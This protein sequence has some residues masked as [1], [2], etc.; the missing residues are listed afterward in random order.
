MTKKIEAI[1]LDTGN[2]LRI[3]VPDAA[4]Q[5]AA[6]QQIVKLVGTQE[7]PDAFCE[8][9]TKRYAAYKETAY[10]TLL[11][12]SEKEL[13]TRWML[14]EYPAEKIMPLASRLTR[15]WLD[16]SGHRVPHSD[17]RPTIIELSNRG[18]L[19]GIIANS[20][21]ETEIPEW[22]AADGLAQYFK[23]VMLSSKFGRR[24]PD[25][26]I[27]LEAARAIGVKPENCAYVGD[28]P[29]RDIQGAR[30]AGYGMVLILLEQATLEKEPSRGKYKPDG[31]LSNCSE[32]LNI[33]F[34]R[35][36]V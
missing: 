5:A 7:Q 31:I 10:R 12:S 6:K 32:M 36:D 22:L 17:V 23:T 24:K 21:S 29:S 26:Y 18:Y 9:L 13:W 3:V 34:P 8:L 16:Q 11:Q 2:T 20:V 28:N 14:P 30:Q 15:L 27:F 4:F 1:F 19:L 33:F 35:T 25:P